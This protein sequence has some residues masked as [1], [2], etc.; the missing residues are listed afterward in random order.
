MWILFHVG[1]QGNERADVLA[2]EG[3]MSG[4][5][6][7]DQAGLTT[8]NSSDIHSRASTRLLT[9]WQVRWND[10]DMD[11]YCYSIVPMVLVK[12]WMDDLNGVVVGYA[13]CYFK[14]PGFESWVSHCPFQKV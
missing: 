9:E 13:D 10:S 7:Q 11:R 6:F 12:A 5:L 2:N 3:S 8:V 4:A 1:I 14:G